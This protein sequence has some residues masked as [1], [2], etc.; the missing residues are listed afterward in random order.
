MIRLSS[1]IPFPIGLFLIGFRVHHFT[2]GCKYVPHMIV[3]VVY[4][5]SRSLFVGHYHRVSVLVHMH[6]LVFVLFA[7][8]L[9]VAL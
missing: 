3:L 5:S 7:L 4:L 6:F 1:Q 2:H 9:D 8:G